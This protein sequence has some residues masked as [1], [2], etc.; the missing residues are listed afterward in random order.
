LFR[1]SIKSEKNR[2]RKIEKRKNKVE[3]S[4][5]A[6]EEGFGA[7]FNVTMIGSTGKLWS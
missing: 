6:K 7:N 2:P 5:I 1:Q 3:G 4:E